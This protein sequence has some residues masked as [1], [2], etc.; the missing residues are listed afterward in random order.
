MVALMTNLGETLSDLV[1]YPDQD[2]LDSAREALSL[3]RE[4]NSRC[5]EYL[6]DFLGKIEGKDQGE[7]EELYTL[8]FDLN[9]V[10]C[11]DT[12]WHLHGEN[13]DRGAYMVKVR[14]LLREFE[15]EETEELP[16]HLSHLLTL[17]ARM[18]PEDAAAFLEKWLGPA[19][20]KILEKFEGQDNPM[21]LVLM[22]I[23]TWLTE[24]F[25]REDLA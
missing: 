6:Q 1:H 15:V 12:G 3:A 23:R 10:S 8:T 11:L 9:P 14:A 22:A 7:L 20:G 25:G 4:Q 21:G 18:E 17:V 2:Y 19:L 16:D 5:A 13:Y 24:S